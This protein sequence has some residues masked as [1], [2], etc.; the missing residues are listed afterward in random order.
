MKNEEYLPFSIREGHISYEAKLK[1]NLKGMTPELRTAIWNEIYRLFVKNYNLTQEV[2]YKNWVEKLKDEKFYEDF[3]FKIW[4]EIINKDVQEIKLL[5]INDFGFIVLEKA[6]KLF[7][8]EYY[9]LPWFK[10]YDAIEL[11]TFLLQKEMENILNDPVLSIHRLKIINFYNSW[12]EDINSALKRNFAPYRLLKEGL[13]VPITNET[14]I[15]TI[16]EALKKS[17]GKFAPVYEHLKKS[18]KFFSH[19]ENP[20]YENTIKEAVS[21]LESLANILLN[22]K[23]RSLT[24]LHQKLA[25]EFNLPKFVELQIK[26]LYNWASNSPIR[27]GTGEK[28]NV[29]GQEEAYLIL[30][31]TSALIN[32]LLSKAERLSK[33]EQK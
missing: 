28:P 1:K 10:V 5:S 11:I 8:D 23:G 33:E 21:A 27:H 3:L 29:I 6:L 14:E 32:Y 13:V 9:K 16:E 24:A 25:S 20:D 22:R 18:I 15:K 4:S 31:Q 7:K 12:L 17:Y 2:F 19:R 26:E 30:V